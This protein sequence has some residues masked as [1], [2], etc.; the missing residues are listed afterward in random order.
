MLTRH[1]VVRPVGLDGCSRQCLTWPKP[2]GGLSI[3][4]APS[5]LLMDPDARVAAAPDPA[6]GQ[7]AFPDGQAEPLRRALT[8][9]ARADDPELLL[10]TARAGL[11]GTFAI[12][13]MCAG[14]DGATP[15]GYPRTEFGRSLAFTAQL[16]GTQPELRVIH[17]PVPL[18]F[19]THDNQPQR[20]ATNL[21]VL[22]A[23]VDALMRDLD[24]RGLSS[25][26]A[27]VVTSEFGRRVQ[28]NGSRGTDHGGANTLFVI[29]PGLRTNLAGAPPPLNRLDDDGNLVPTVSYRDYL[30][31]AIEGWMGVPASSILPGSRPVSL[32]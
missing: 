26:T 17:I 15:A 3:A 27:V 19:D 2:L 1:A 22:D 6:R 12:H 31:A 30:A 32:W 11:E 10:R 29:A 14:L 16:L 7:F 8:A 9:L 25:T 18:D 24:S 13:E 21:A 23:G 20:Q 28:D 4:P 5:P